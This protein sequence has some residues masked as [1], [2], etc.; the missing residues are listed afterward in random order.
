MPAMPQ[1]NQ[2]TENRKRIN[3]GIKILP[4][5]MSL[6]ENRQKKRPTYAFINLMEKVTGR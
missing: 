5:K 1:V 6:V 4:F 3:I 2:R